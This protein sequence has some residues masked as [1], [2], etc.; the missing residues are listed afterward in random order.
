M[1]EDNPD[2][3]QAERAPASDT[4][5]V[6]A[7]TPSDAFEA[8][9][10]DLRTAVLLTLADE[11][12]CSFARGICPDCGGASTATVER[13]REGDTGSGT[14]DRDGPEGGWPPGQVQGWTAR[15][16]YVS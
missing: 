10:N 16:K 6:E 15:E 5:V 9:G 3:V 12:P 14:A 11:G 4:V 8:L 7:A 13:V 1:A 2:P